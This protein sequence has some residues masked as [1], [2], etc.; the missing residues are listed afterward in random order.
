M[1]AAGL[2]HGSYI[3][4][5]AIFPYS[6]I[7]MG[8]MSSGEGF[9]DLE[10]RILPLSAFTQFGVYGF[11]TGKAWVRGKMKKTIIIL[12]ASHAV[13]LLAIAA[14]FLAESYFRR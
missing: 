13:V 6:S 5:F 10:E 9:H 12:S 2:G 8:F 3:P 7:L 14:L 11:L 1:N 4:M